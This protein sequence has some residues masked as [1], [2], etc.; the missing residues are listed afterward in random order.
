MCGLT[1]SL[2]LIAGSPSADAASGAADDLAPLLDSL[3]SSNA[4]RGPDSSQT[5]IERID[6]SSGRV[7]EVSLSA[8]V[9]GLRGGLTAQP[10]VGK[11]GV[12]GWNGQ[13]FDGL[14]VPV[15]E[16]DTRKVFEQLE[17]GESISEVLSGI[18]GP[19]AFIYLDP[20]AKTLSFQTDPLTRR[21]LL[22]H[23]PHAGPSRTFLLSSTRSALAREQAIPMRALLG[24][25][26]GQV[27]LE[28]IDVV[29]DRGVETRVTPIVPTLPPPAIP[30]ISDEAI[31]EFIAHLQ[32]SVRRRVENIPAPPPGAARAAVLFSGGVDSTFLAYMLHRVLP[33]SEPIDLINI[34]F[35]PEEGVDEVDVE[36]EP[37]PPNGLSAADHARLEKENGEYAVPDRIGGREALDEL[38][39]TCEREWRFVEV[40]V[41]FDEYKAHRQRV[42]DLMYPCTTE[43][44]LSLAYPLYFASRGTGTLPTPSG[45][46]AYQVRSKVYFSGLGPD[47]RNTS[48][49]DRLLSSFA[50][51]ARYPY[52]DLSFVAYL[53]SLPIHAK[54]D[55]TANDGMGDKRILRLA[56]DRVGLGETARRVKRAMQFGSRSAKVGGAGKGPRAGQRAVE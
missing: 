35:Q 49:D 23:P 31:D 44:D 30:P 3:R 47:D 51:D 2:R 41:P 24:G 56:V 11:R 28:D 48:R 21:S 15:G 14:D 26:G 50:R 39:R 54:F 29:S 33:A 38:K 18:E 20:R 42:V 40:D 32:G 34:A 45:R 17:R 10:L 13:V 53:S 6:L 22:L 27:R 25:E 1:L 12:L 43:M 16:N 8:S 52:L 55:P 9:L 5:H 19:Y 46:E 7:L 37:R 36:G 4:L